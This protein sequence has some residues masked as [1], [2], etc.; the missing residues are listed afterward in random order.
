[1]IERKIADR[2]ADVRGELFLLV[3]YLD[4]YIDATDATSEEQTKLS[5]L[6]GE[7]NE[8]MVKLNHAVTGELIE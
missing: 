4:E 6:I 8:A 5:N 3:S 7:A 2:I 1:M